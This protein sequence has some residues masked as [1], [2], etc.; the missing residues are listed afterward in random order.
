[1]ASESFGVAAGDHGFPASAAR[2]TATGHLR[3]AAARLLKSARD[4]VAAAAATATRAA[5]GVAI[6]Q[7][8]VTG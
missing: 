2:T 4:E 5:P 7:D 6:E 8:V 3:G 1:M